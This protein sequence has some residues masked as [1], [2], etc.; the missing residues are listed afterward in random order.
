MQFKGTILK[1]DADRVA[2]SIQFDNQQFTMY[3][4]SAMIPSNLDVGS[5]FYMKISDKPDARE[6]FSGNGKSLDELRE[7]LYELI[8]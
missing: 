8:N 5:P 4:P 6:E 7:L 1:K 3:W 2:T